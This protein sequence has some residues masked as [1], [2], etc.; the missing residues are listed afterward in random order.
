MLA[1]NPNSPRFTGNTGILFFTH[2]RAAKRTVPSPPSV[3]TKSN[4]VNGF[5]V[6]K[7][8]K[9]NTDDSIDFAAR[10]DYIILPKF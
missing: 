10:Y 1:I 9:Q 7:P 8:S 2:P 3:I 4:P 5:S 6:L